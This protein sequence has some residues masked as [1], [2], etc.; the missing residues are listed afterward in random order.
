[1]IEDYV[2]R[3]PEIKA[4]QVTEVVSDMLQL[5]CI[6]HAERVR[7]EEWFKTGKNRDWTEFRY[8]LTHGG[9]VYAGDWLL[10]NGLTWS[11]MFDKE[12]RQKYHSKSEYLRQ[13]PV[14]L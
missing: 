1:M 11:V 12:F 4:V 7:H 3:E 10:Y 14:T 9:C 6:D 5:D 13:K 8:I 2:V